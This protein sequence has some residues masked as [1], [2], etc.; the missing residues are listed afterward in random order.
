MASMQGRTGRLGAALCGLAKG[1]GLFALLALLLV[2]VEAEAKDKEPGL[3]RAKRDGR[4]LYRSPD[5]R[6]WL[7]RAPSGAL[8]VDGRSLGLS[9]R[10]VGRPVWRR[11]GR[12][13]AVLQRKRHLLQ[14]VVLADLEGS[15]P[16]VWRV[17]TL[18]GMRPYIQWLGRQAVGLGSARLVPRVIFRW[19][20][21]LASR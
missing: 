16:L 2:G 4:L 15:E 20:T 3:R 19:T 6:H 9:G 13:L 5:G 21:H 18:V 17:P 10:Q 1:V 12:A 11:D 8:F 14:L 7:W